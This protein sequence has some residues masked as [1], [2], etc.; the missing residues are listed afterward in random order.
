MPVVPS[1]PP[2]VPVV[3]STPP[4]ML[5][6]PSSPTYCTATKSSV[7]PQAQVLK[8]KFKQATPISGVLTATVTVGRP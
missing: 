1:T 3:P 4:R 8:L 2:R 7:S 6:A 5:G